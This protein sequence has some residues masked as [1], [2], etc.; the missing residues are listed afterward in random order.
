MLR[1]VLLVLQRDLGERPRDSVCLYLAFVKIV[2]DFLV[3]LF[4]QLSLCRRLEPV[5]LNEVSCTRIL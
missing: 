4:F 2:D 1:I 3:E 5:P